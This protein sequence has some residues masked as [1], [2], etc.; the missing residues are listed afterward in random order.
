MCRFGSIAETAFGRDTSRL[1]AVG[2]K[3]VKP[4]MKADCMFLSRWAEWLKSDG[5]LLIVCHE[6]TDIWLYV[7]EPNVWSRLIVDCMFWVE[8]SFFYSK[9]GMLY[10]CLYSTEVL[11]LSS[12]LVLSMLIHA[13]GF[14]RES[15]TY[16]ELWNYTSGRP[17]CVYVGDMRHLVVTTSPIPQKPIS[18]ESCH[19]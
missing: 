8:W 9:S 3:K 4:S 11:G 1:Q 5:W 7:V 16:A 18:T 6:S 17:V 14:M 15:G 19:P 12:K 2:E 10:V 13:P